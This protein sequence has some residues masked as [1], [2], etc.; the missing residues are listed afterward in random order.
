VSPTPEDY[1]K[2]RELFAWVID[3]VREGGDDELAIGDIARAL[4]SARAEWPEWIPVED[5][6]PELC[7]WVLG[8]RAGSEPTTYLWDE[9][10]WQSSNV[11]RIRSREYWPT[12]WLPLPPQPKVAP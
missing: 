9:D 10:G 7:Q 1:A 4:A 2:A 6:M 8:W 5:R 11:S 3:V 12:H